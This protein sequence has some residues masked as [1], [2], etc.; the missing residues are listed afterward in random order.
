MGAL[1]RALLRALLLCVVGV[2]PAF[3]LVFN[4]LFSDSQGPGDLVLGLGVTFL[5]YLLPAVVVG[6]LWPRGRFGNAAWLL[7]PAAIVALSYAAQEP[8]IVPLGLAELA[9][10][11]VGTLV[12]AM[13]GASFRSGGGGDRSPRPNG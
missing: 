11:S 4:A 10:A 12:G 1:L 7:L 6:L 5:G 8:R 2:V 3:Y 13:V 9:A